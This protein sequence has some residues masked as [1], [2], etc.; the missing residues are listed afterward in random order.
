MREG[1]G[2]KDVTHCLSGHW[3]AGGQHGRVGGRGS[4]LP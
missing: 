1:E 4:L 2:T 3:L